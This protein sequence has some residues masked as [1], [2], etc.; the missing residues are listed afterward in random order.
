[1]FLL[2]FNSIKFK[3][4]A[5]SSDRMI[6]NFSF[7]FEVRNIES[8]SNK[9][10]HR[11]FVVLVITSSSFLIEE[12]STPTSRNRLTFL[13]PKF[14]L[15]KIV[16][17]LI[18]IRQIFTLAVISQPTLHFCESHNKFSKSYFFLCLRRY[19]VSGSIRSVG[20]ILDR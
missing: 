6:G 1:M 9:S 11:V 12:V 15:R 20:E 19:G 8:I 17:R 16:Y 14:V 3:N 7:E 5:C 18:K 10:T 13:K 4:K 2:L